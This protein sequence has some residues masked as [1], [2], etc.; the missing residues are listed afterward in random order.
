MFSRLVFVPIAV[1]LFVSS[2]WCQQLDNAGN[3]PSLGNN[4]KPTAGQGGDASTSS[5]G[6][7]VQFNSGN[8]VNPVSTNSSDESKPPITLVSKGSGKLPNEQG[9]VWREYDISPYTTR[10][11]S[12]ERPEQAIVDWILRETG[13]EVWFSE[14][15]G[16]LNATRD[17]L[18]VYHTEEMQRLVLDV[19]ERFVSSQGQTHS[20]SLRLINIS[21][22]NW[23]T[24]AMSLMQPINVQ[25]TGVEAWLL[26]KEHAAMLLGQL[27]QRSDF[28]E[29]HS[30]N[31]LVQNG[32][33]FTITRT[34]PK[35]YVRSVR[36]QQNVWPGH[37]VEMGQ[38]QEG[39][40]LQIS[41]LFSLDGNTVDAVIKCQ[42]D[43]IE[44]LVSVPVDVPSAGGG[45]QRIQIQVPQVVAWRLHERF[46]W[47]ADQVLLLGCGVI[48]TPTPEQ[49]DVLGLKIPS[50]PLPGANRADALL[51][52]ETKGTANQT[53]LEAQRGYSQ[54][55]PTSNGR[56]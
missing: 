35:N 33:A 21:S 23:R 10:I 50:L 1:L 7:A 31:G 42:I 19:V 38:L 4:W 34:T 51:M 47:P 22:P 13:T 18:R 14:P 48:A 17:K 29:Q 39:F 15:L 28:R 30:P 46:R 3:V 12:T 44:K 32:Q 36:M 43:Q 26:S 24:S 11:N 9:Q 45:A 37:Q 54:G 25:S 20:I 49:I 55:T 41:P 5:T 27:K 56:Y 53:S 6:N 16:I 2:G 8:S 52:I 40:S